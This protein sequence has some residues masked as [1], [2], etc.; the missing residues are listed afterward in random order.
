[1]GRTIVQILR[2]RKVTTSVVMVALTLGVVSSALAAN[3][4]NFI[5]G[6]LSNSATAV[7]RLTMTGTANGSV[8]QL[9]QQST[10]T[11]ASG[12]GIT[13]PAGKAPIT[14]NSTAGKATNLNADKLDSLD[15]T[16]LQRRVSGTCAAGQSISS[17]AALGTVSCETDD[18][19]GAALRSELGT[20]DAGGPN[21]ASDPVSYS[22][23]KDIPAD[24][25]DRNADKLDGEDSTA[26]QKR[27]SGE[28]PAGESI[29]AIAAD[30]STVTC[31]ADDQGSEGGTI[32]STGTFSGVI[33]D[34]PLPPA[35]AWVFAGP[36]TT[37]TTTADQG[38]F[39]VGEAAMALDSGGPQPFDYGLC[40]QPSA[41][42]TITNFVGGNYLI[43]ELTTTRVSWGASAARAPGAG[44]WKV[45][46]CVRSTVTI[47]DNDYV[48]GWVQV[49]NPSSD[50]SAAAPKAGAPGTPARE[51]ATP[52]EATAP[53][54]TATAAPDAAAVPPR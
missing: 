9:I 11:G 39:G 31:E 29:R 7:T 28:C 36:T 13:V 43:G 19:S 46:F 15:S 25:V 27:V 5:L 12:L 49:L 52:A 53:A 41:G 1:M 20:T 8:L 40:F 6:V 33:G 26:Y 3:G 4:G 35:G 38:L 32:A 23:V 42:G 37:V 2:R 34:I 30:G 54:G 22:K 21:E 17:I 16:A 50:T 10:G 14:V 18:D 47:N 51:P 48:N 45:G 24:V 44:T